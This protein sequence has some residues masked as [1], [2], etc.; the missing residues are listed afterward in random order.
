MFDLHSEMHTF[1]KE[2]VQLGDE[3]DQLREYRDRNVARLKEGLTKLGYRLPVKFRN[4]GGYATHTLTQRPESNPDVDHDIDVAVMF[5]KEDLPESPLDARKRVLAGVKEGG[6]NFKK[7][8][9]ART[10]A[11]TVWY[12]EKYHV[13][14]PVFR[15]Y[16]DAWGQEIVEHAGA[17][18]SPRDPM[19]ITNW[20]NDKVNALSPS[21][22]NG[23]TV[24][25]QQMRRIVQ[26][27]K[28]FSKSRPSWELPGGLIISV[29]VEECYCPDYYR[30]D[31]GL[32]NTMRSI[33]DRIRIADGV[34][35][36]E[37]YNP[38]DRSQRLTYKDK[39]I[40]QVKRFGD[41]LDAAI[42]W[43]SPLQDFDCA[44][45]DALSAWY[46]V[47]QH[48]YWEKLAEEVEEA[49]SM[50]EQ[51]LA[52]RIANSLYVASS[53]RV[54]TSKPTGK[55]VQIQDHRFYGV[56]ETTDKTP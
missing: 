27:L 50:G 7:E 20:F 2:H 38:V 44:K 36:A 45:E 40:A 41:K 35:N 31:R 13:D 9:E 26:F 23:A 28:Y 11:V 53:G 54:H 30:D 32:Y 22:D 18:W 47:F 49:K 46:K 8:P 33:R 42:Q 5:K 43:L 3:K 6:G 4:Q 1:Y 16:N 34:Y 55:S 29:L 25:D 12:Q 24:K 56:N 17:V 21:Q 19:D 39:H 14:L 10:N 48:S 51:L 15:F 52:A 37:V